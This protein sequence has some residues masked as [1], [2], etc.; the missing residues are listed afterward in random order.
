MVL[1]LDFLGFVQ[2][3]FRLPKEFVFGLLILGR[4][5]RSAAHIC[6][7]LWVHSDLRWILIHLETDGGSI[8]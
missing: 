8:V 5:G 7:I 4:R 6:C 2:G 3:F 1:H